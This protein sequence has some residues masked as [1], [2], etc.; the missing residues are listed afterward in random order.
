MFDVVHASK[1]RGGCVG[2][3]FAC[4]RLGLRVPPV[5]SYNFSPPLQLGEQSAATHFS[6]HFVSHALTEQWVS[7]FSTHPWQRFVGGLGGLLLTISFGL[8]HI[9]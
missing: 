2:F 9:F 8:M 7:T 6:R 5:P 4:V 1:R 3:F